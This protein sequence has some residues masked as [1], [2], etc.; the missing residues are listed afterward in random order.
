MMYSQWVR[1]ARGSTLAIAGLAALFAGTLMERAHAAQDAEPGPE[2]T[3]EILEVKPAQAL[4]GAETTLSIGGKNFA[5]GVYVSF[6][7]PLLHAVSTQRISAT[8]LEVRI[9]VGKKA[10]P[11]KVSLYVSNTASVVAETQ[12]TIAAQGGP[13][14]AAP[15]PD[16]GGSAPAQPNPP[17]ASQPVATQGPTPEIKKIDPPVAP[18]GGQLDI[19]VTGK[20]FVKGAKVVFGNPGI[21]VVDTQVNKDTELVARIQVRADATPGET[22]LFVVN[23]N[24]EETEA[25]FVLSEEVTTANAAAPPA[26]PS[27]PTTPTAP[28]APAPAPPAA[29]PAAPSTPAQPAAPSSTPPAAKTSATAQRFE[30][31]SLADVGSIIQARNAPKG[32]L[33]VDGGKLRFEESGKEVFSVAASDI[34]E[35]EINSLLGV[36]TGTFHIILTSGKMYNFA[37][38]SLRPADTQ[39][40]VESLRKA[41]K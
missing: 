25:A 24:E 15:G 2:S 41:L 30:V 8:Q 14:S 31:Y 29:P 28:A 40:M 34:K 11:G 36:N 1:R 27:V 18:R 12:L 6:S 16:L 39:V 35:V 13:T 38:T 10:Q 33:T 4:V 17:A 9:E 26:A 5:R 23:P 21:L 37:A 19:K 7:T 3:P 32:T 22:N 20:N